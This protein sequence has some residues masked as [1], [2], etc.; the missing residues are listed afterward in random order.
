MSLIEL[1][2]RFSQLSQLKNS[3]ASARALGY[4]LIYVW[5][6]LRRPEVTTVSRQRLMELSGLNDTT[7]RRSLKYLSDIALIKRVSARSK[8]DVAFYWRIDDREMTPARRPAGLINTP[9]SRVKVREEKEKS[10][11]KDFSVSEQ[12]VKEND[13]RASRPVFAEQLPEGF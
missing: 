11:D 13:N 6:E 5:N 12:E 8:F 9:A 2:R 4:T 1:F 3:T 7:F 10:S